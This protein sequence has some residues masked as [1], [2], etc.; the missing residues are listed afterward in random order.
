ML[1]SIIVRLGLFTKVTTP[2]GS[3]EAIHAGS[4]PVTHTRIGEKMQ[5]LYTIRGLLLKKVEALLP[6]GSTYPFSFG[7]FS[8]FLDNCGPDY[9]ILVPHIKLLTTHNISRRVAAP[10]F[11]LLAGLRNLYLKGMFHC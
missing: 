9:A 2:S 5:H 1:V 4:R 8:I 3:G 6:Y 10:P 11:S 7:K